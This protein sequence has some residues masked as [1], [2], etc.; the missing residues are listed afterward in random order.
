MDRPKYERYM[1]LS[2]E[3]SVE[4]NQLMDEYAKFKKVDPIKAEQLILEAYKKMN[5]STEALLTA[6]D[7]AKTNGKL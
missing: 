1:R 2:K 4:Y 6:L 5:A 3:L 7:A